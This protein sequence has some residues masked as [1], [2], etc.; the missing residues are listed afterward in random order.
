MVNPIRLLKF[1]AAIFEMLA[2]IGCFIGTSASIPGNIPFYVDDSAKTYLSIP[3]HDEWRG[4]SG[5]Q[6]AM[7][8]RV[9]QD[10]LKGLNYRSDD[11]CRESGGFFED[12]WNLTFFLLSKIGLFPNTIIGGIDPIE[13][14][15]E[16]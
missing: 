7:L 8:R 11:I 4:R 2:I 16:S 14:K 10:D 15:A 9:S 3:C 6:I 5:N 13:P 1:I 12:D